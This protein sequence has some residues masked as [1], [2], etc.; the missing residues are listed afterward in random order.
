MYTSRAKFQWNLLLTELNLV[1]II[2]DL[3]L[4]LCESEGGSVID[5]HFQNSFSLK[6]PITLFDVILGFSYN[7]V[8]YPFG[9]F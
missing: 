4:I 3:A 1:N 2:Y 7:L 9:I 5:P 8:E 6:I